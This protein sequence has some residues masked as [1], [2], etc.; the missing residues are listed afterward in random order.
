LS[1]N[2]NLRVILD[3]INR[4][5][6]IFSCIK[7]AFL[8]REEEAMENGLRFFLGLH[9]EFKLNRISKED[10]AGFNRQDLDIA[11]IDWQ[12]VF[13]MQNALG[14]KSDKKDFITLFSEK[15]FALSQDYHYYKSIF[16]YII[17]YNS[18][19]C[20]NFLGD[21]KKYFPNP[22]DEADD[23]KTYK[24]LANDYG[25]LNVEE[26]K[27]YTS[28]LVDFAEQGK[29]PLIDTV[30][31]V[32]FATR[33]ENPNSYNLDELADRL[34]TGMNLFA[35][36]HVYDRML[37]FKVEIPDNHEYHDVM[38]RIADVAKQINSGKL[39]DIYRAQSDLFKKIFEEDLKGFLEVV[40]Q[41]RNLDKI[42][43]ASFNPSEL[44]DKLL[45]VFTHRQVAIFTNFI[46]NKY[47]GSF[48]ESFVSDYS[49][50]I[51]VFEILKKVKEDELN[52]LQ[53][54]VIIEL[55]QVLQRV[56]NNSKNA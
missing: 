12:A 34:I 38:V 11:N 39:A 50:L 35:A 10:I 21:L 40:S 16:N 54:P 32:Y 1:A 25:D 22:Q 4:F 5:E 20:N 51:N 2:S 46:K 18:L 6:K 27:K 48:I 9:I 13:R 45:T 14:D 19:D 36:K 3:G 44:V 33:L 17:Y 41:E 23:V 28:N 56:F 53:K 37:D 24:L 31:I 30:S 47:T 8:V 49:F 26:Y 7:Q 29:Y 52:F 43:F 15:Y 55:M 42:V